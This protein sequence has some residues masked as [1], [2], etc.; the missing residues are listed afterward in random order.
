MTMTTSDLQIQT[1]IPHAYANVLYVL[2]FSTCHHPPSAPPACRK[3]GPPSPSAPVPGSD[4]PREPKSAFLSGPRP[5]ELV[6]ILVNQCLSFL[7]GVGQL[8]T[9]LVGLRCFDGSGQLSGGISC[10]LMSQISLPI[11]SD[12]LPL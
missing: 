10:V 11:G 5:L 8:A 4:G 12:R 7:A 3:A 1:Y 6:A 9:C 2:L